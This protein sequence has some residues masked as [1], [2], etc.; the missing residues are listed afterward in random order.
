VLLALLILYQPALG[1]TLKDHR[2]KVYGIWQDNRLVAYKLR[3]RDRRITSSG[4][5]SSQIS[6]LNPQKKSFRLGP[7][8]VVWNDK[9]IF[10]GLTAE[11]LY[12][13]YSVRVLGRNSNAG[14]ITALRIE[15]GNVDTAADT[16]K[17]L[18]LVTDVQKQKGFLAATIMGKTVVIPGSLISSAYLLTRKQDD[19]RPSEQLKIQLFGKPLTI[20]GEIGVTPRYRENFNLDPEKNRDRVRLDNEAQL[21]LFYSWSVNLAFFLEGQVA[22]Q[23]DLYRGNNGRK[24]SQAELK[25]GES[26]MFWGE[27]L[28]SNF[29]LQVG[30]QNF[31]E[32][33]EWWWDEDLDALRLYYHRP[34]LH[35]ELGISEQLFPVST[36]DFGIPA[37]DQDVLRILSRTS[38]EWA[39]KQ[40]LGLFFLYQNDHSGK[41]S[42]AELVRDEF[43]DPVDGN[44]TWLGL[45]TQNRFSPENS[46]DF[47]FWTDVAWV[48]G[49]ESSID[50]VNSAVEGISIVDGFDDR[51]IQGWAA[52]VGLTW[53]VPV[54]WSPSLTI[55]YAI[56][57]RDFRQTGLQ[58]NNDRFRAIS[59]F[60]YYG[61]LLRPELANLQIW[62]MAASVPFWKNSSV[63]ALYHYY[64]QV[65]AQPFL[66]RGRINPDP[67]GIS[68]DI[69]QEWDLVVALEEWKHWELEFVTAAFRAGPAYG[70]KSGNVAI[71]MIFK[72]NYNF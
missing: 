56:G 38:W 57:S 33:R 6:D 70:E 69:G 20:G 43:L 11:D 64:R 18:G 59:R 46:G 42:L 24:K 41:Q 54:S 15:P 61:E 28:E 48:T 51:H 23:Q 14:R 7:Y 21:E 40:Y 4:I 67:N 12:D 34:F 49:R 32:T 22:Y 25:R 65:D 60:R 37:E 55:G 29:S 53:E 52:D 19:R 35:F 62:T 3:F 8:L 39:R 63:T 71:N 72:I 16:V 45:R 27:I 66:R 50:F 2:I 58:D 30:R 10:K 1:L 13:G 47:D 44:F 36:A 5:I 31:R 26:W 9:S 17:I 68:P